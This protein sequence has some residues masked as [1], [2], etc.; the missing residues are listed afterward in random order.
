VVLGLSFG[1][2]SRLQRRDP[3]SFQRRFL[4]E[5]E[6]SFHVLV[7]AAEIVIR[8]RY[9]GPFKKGKWRKSDK[10]LVRIVR[11]E[12]NQPVFQVR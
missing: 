10:A 12:S 6:E 9:N 3:T 5:F 1:N 4:E 8:F 2:L 11:H 7:K